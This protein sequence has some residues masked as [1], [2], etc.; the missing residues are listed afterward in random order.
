MGMTSAKLSSIDSPEEASF[1]VEAAL[2]PTELDTKPTPRAVGTFSIRDHHGFE[3]RLNM[4]TAVNANSK[5]YVSACE[6]GVFGGQVKPFQGLASMEVHNVVPH[7]DGIVI[8]R[9]YIGW[10]TDINV[11]LNVF[12]A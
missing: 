9:G 10:D 4:G 12:V 1:S 2:A 11:R 8:V 5:V 6:L 7:D 3:R